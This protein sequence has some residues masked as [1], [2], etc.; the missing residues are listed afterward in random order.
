MRETIVVSRRRAAPPAPRPDRRPAR[1]DRPARPS[2]GRRT[3]TPRRS[4]R[5]SAAAARSRRPGVL[6]DS[7]DEP[8][9]AD[10]AA[11]ASASSPSA[12]TSS[13]SPGCARR[14]GASALAAHFDPP[15]AAPELRH[16]R[17]RSP[18][19]TARTRSSRACCSSA[20][21]ASRLGWRPE[22]LTRHGDL[23]RGRARGRRGEV[24]LRLEPV[25]GHARAG[26]RGRRDRAR[27]SGTMLA[28]ERGAGGLTARAARARR[29]RAHVDGAR[30]VARRGRASSA[31]ASARRCC[32]TRPTRRRSPPR[33][34]CS[35]EAG[36]RATSRSAG[37]PFPPIADYALPVGLR[38]VRARR[39]ERQ[40]RVDV[41]AAHGRPER[42][43]RDA[44]PRRRRVP[45]SRR[46]DAVVPAGRRYLPGTNILETTW[47]TKTGWLIVRD[48]LLVGPWR[49]DRERSHTHR[50]SPTD[51]DAEHVLLR[52]LRC[53]NGTVEMHLECEPDLRLRARAGRAGSTPATATRQCTATFEG[54]DLEL[55]LHDRP[56]ARASRATR[57]RARTTMHDGDLALRRADWSDAP[58][59]RR[60]TRRPTS[61]S[62]AR[63]TTGTSGSRRASSPTTRG[64]TYLQRSRA[65]AEGAVVRADRRDGRGGDDVAARDARRRAQLGLPLLAGCAT[66]RSCSGASTRSASTGRPTTS[67]TSSPR[68]CEEHDLQVMYGIGGE[69]VARGGGR[70]TTSTATRTRAPVRIGNG[71]Y[72]HR[73]HDVW[74]TLP[75]LVLPAH[76]VARRAARVAS[77][78]S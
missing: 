15:T 34:A 46:A 45:R 10:G 37:S 5:S 69:R 47:G 22:R 20:G 42:L 53:V 41:P 70:S 66:R 39:A 77:G 48:V 57:A 54:C 67:S 75:R 78:R 73:Q 55:R 76:E 74:G 44:R 27:T 52:T 11:T 63:R 38:D 8:E 71:A 9:A 68:S 65:D 33:G 14:R 50:R 49:H 4:T 64:A 29:R 62:C 7:V 60:A 58:P 21:C 18:C 30:R 72:N 26:P 19:A 2:S 1:R 59:A 28:L 40:R 12:S 35:H 23:L 24:E 13:T 61:G 6:C 25:D 32:A 31:R 3:A 36:R 51:Y 56:A 17:R 43:R 16:A